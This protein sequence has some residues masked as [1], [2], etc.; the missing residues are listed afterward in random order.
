MQSWHQNALKKISFSIKP[1]RYWDSDTNRQV[2][3]ATRHAD[4]YVMCLLK[5]KDKSTVN[6][7][8]MAQWTFY[9]LSRIELDN[10]MRSKHSITLASLKRLTNSVDYNNLNKEIYLKNTL[11]KSLF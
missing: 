7:L 6:P 2:N 1:S 9:V 11:P 4:I 8:D 5:H 10:Y 3:E